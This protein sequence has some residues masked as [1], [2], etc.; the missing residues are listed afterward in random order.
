MITQKEK[1]LSSIHDEVEFLN[2]Y[3]LLNG[4]RGHAE[5]ELTLKTVTDRLVQDHRRDP[6][7]PLQLSYHT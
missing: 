5:V 3:L 6:P 2:K 4:L 1:V 7:E